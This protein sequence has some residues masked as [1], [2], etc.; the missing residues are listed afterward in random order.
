MT[1][2]GA[3]GRVPGVRAHVHTEA[4]GEMAAA[5]PTTGE[6]KPGEEADL[7][8]IQLLLR[9]QVP[10]GAD[11]P[12]GTAPQAMAGNHA[13]AQLLALQRMAGNEAT[14]LLLAQPP[15]RTMRGIGAAAPPRRAPAAAN[16]GPPA[17]APRQ[18]TDGGLP[19]GA[20]GQEALV[21]GGNEADMLAAP[22]ASLS[23]GSNGSGPPAGGYGIKKTVVD[24][25]TFIGGNDPKT[26]FETGIRVLLELT[27][28]FPIVNVLG[29]GV[30]DFLQLDLDLK[31]L[32]DDAPWTRLTVIIRD[33]LALVNNLAGSIASNVEY[34]QDAATS[35]GA[36]AAAGAATAPANAGIKGVKV[37]LDKAL[38]G[39]DVLIESEAVY[40]RV[41]APKNSDEAQQ[42]N[43]VIGNFAVS[44]V[45]DTIGTVIDYIDMMTG[46]FANGE[47]L[48]GWARTFYQMLKLSTKTG[49]ILVPLINNVA[50]VHGWGLAK[51]ISDLLPGPVPEPEPGWKPAPPSASG[52]P[53][54]VQRLSAGPDGR[55]ALEL[56]AVEAFMSEVEQARQAWK[57][58]DELI[59]AG[60][61]NFRQLEAQMRERAIELTGGIDP[62]IVMRDQARKSLDRA[63]SAV[64]ELSEL[65]QTALEVFTDST[66][67][68]AACE[69]ALG[70]L[71]VVRIP[72]IH[73]PASSG[74]GVLADLERRGEAAAD[75]VLQAAIAPIRAQI[76][77]LRGQAE[78]PIQTVKGHAGEIADF[79]KV[80]EEQCVKEA[81]ALQ[82]QIAKLSGAL[83]RVQNFE[84]LVDVL[85]RQ[86][87]EA[88]GIVGG[89]GLADVRAAWVEVDSI[90]ERAEALGQDA[91]RGIL[92]RRAK[93]AAAAEGSS[94]L[95]AG[96]GP[97]PEDDPDPLRS[98]SP[99]ARSNR[100]LAAPA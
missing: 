76:D 30:A 18:P 80:F 29:G 3:G 31:S 61:A 1:V 77:S 72:A 60:V 41:H 84:Q 97:P 64:G 13:T 38:I 33:G 50:S 56:L 55:A 7:T 96:A 22:S 10:A 43:D 37:A 17:H 70:Q 54:A 99:A 89:I 95:A 4:A 78:A 34:F 82:Q 45:T 49:Q 25:I 48:K 58:G 44:L 27:R 53:G 46:G 81:A 98:G 86:L 69:V 28:P 51:K 75:A 35:T 11:G 91:R 39:L 93:E 20:A 79:S 5:A 73:V 12:R 74:Q 92:A 71:D 85:L 36:G 67:I 19:A 94:A 59:S 47:N 63:S 2:A 24:T 8:T 26:G 66:S 23:A 100:A 88:L 68:V 52:A 14:H 57:V 90:L 42:W 62:F 9:G 15:R 87:T 83:G 32:P 6:V 16:L 21:T 40:N 65:G